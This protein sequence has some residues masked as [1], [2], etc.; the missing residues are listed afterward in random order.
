VLGVAQP[1]AYSTRPGVVG[2]RGEHAVAIELAVDLA[3]IG[4]A[5]LDIGVGVEHLLL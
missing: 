3:Q 4:G 2:G 1:L 5:Q